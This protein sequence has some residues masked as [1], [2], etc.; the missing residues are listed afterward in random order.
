MGLDSSIVLVLN[1]LA[2]SSPAAG[3]L[4]VFI[5]SW[6]PYLIVV[7]FAAYLWRS[8]HFTGREKII[9]LFWALVAALVARIVITSPI[10]FFFP[11]DRP[12]LTLPIHPLFMDHAPSFPSGHSSFFFAFSTVVYAYDKRLGAICFV[13]TTLVCIGRVA[14]GVHYLSD[15]LAGAVV[16]V[17][18]GFIVLKL[19]LRLRRVH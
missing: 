2:N 6:L 17:L 1:A 16:G 19:M 8:H 5:A 3:A 10:R 11:R 18:A 15:I 14:A 4:T 13:L 12:F 7:L 9:P